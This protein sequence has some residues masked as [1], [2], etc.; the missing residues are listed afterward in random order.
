[1]TDAVLWWESMALVL[2]LLGGVTFTLL[3]VIAARWRQSRWME[4]VG[5]AAVAAVA[6]GAVVLAVVTV[7]TW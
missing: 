7:V 5:L 1:M 6:A 3:A 2:M 4:V